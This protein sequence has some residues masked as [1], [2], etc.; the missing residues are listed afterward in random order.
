VPRF[1]RIDT[2]GYRIQPRWRPVGKRPTTAKRGTILV[3]S[4]DFGGHRMW[5][6]CD[7]YVSGAGSAFEFY[8]QVDPG[9]NHR[10]LGGH[11]SSE[12]DATA[13]ALRGCRRLVG[14]K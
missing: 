13:A 10:S 3:P 5:E 1:S 9:L 2:D 7:V 6:P 11:A 14:K 8:V 4:R 12:R